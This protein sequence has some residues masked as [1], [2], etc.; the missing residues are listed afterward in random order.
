MDI[1]ARV[2]QANDDTYAAWNAHDA[3]A[4]AAVFARDAEIFDVASGT[5]TRGRDAI[6]VTAVERFIGFPNFSLEKQT[7][8]IDGPANADRWIM[9][10][11]QTGEF[12][13]LA[14]TGNAVE[15]HGATFSEFN[16]EGLV[17]RD[18]HYVDVGTLMR[19]LGLA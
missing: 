11:T 9:R 15:V 12:M 18:T 4:V 1:R 8:L 13:G 17:V 7:L 5:I 10:G 14:P 3:D 2:Q 16:D 6:R 19:Q